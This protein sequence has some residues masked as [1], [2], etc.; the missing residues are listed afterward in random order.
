MLIITSPHEKFPINIINFEQKTCIKYLSVYIDQ[1]FNLPVL[2]QLYY[3]LIY[4]Y[5]N[6]AV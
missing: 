2:K 3:T 1:H 6:Y 4:P 5:L